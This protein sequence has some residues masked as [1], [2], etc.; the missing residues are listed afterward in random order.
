[1]AWFPFKGAHLIQVKITK[2][3]K[4]RAAT[5][6]PRPLNRGGRLIEVTNIAFVWAK[7]R[8]FENWP[9]NREWP[10]NT[11]PLYTGSTVVLEENVLYIFMANY[12]RFADHIPAPSNKPARKPQARGFAKNQ[13]TGRRNEAAGLELGPPTSGGSITTAICSSWLLACTGRAAEESMVRCN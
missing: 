13:I 5:G 12:L 8:D 1:M 6:W 3:H 7:N 11:G 9:L 2:K 4:H 10:L